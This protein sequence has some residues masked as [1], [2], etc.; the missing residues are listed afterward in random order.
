MDI[1][2]TVVYKI[3]HSFQIR[4][5][6]FHLILP[7]APGRPGSP[8]SPL[9]PWGPTSPTGPSGPASP[10]SPGCPW[11]PEKGIEETIR[12]VVLN[13]VQSTCLKNRSFG[14]FQMAFE[15]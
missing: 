11:A 4:W 6:T 3:A 15:A 2:F 14:I 12:T 13:V 7:G 1:F 10:G 9:G 5:L 8:C